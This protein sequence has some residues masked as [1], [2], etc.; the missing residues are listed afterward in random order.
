MGAGYS[1]S[2]PGEFCGSFVTGE[3]AF[4]SSWDQDVIYGI[5]TDENTIYSSLDSADAFLSCL[6]KGYPNE[7]VS[8]IPSTQEEV[9]Y[10]G[11]I[12]F[13]QESKIVRIYCSQNPL[14]MALVAGEDL[15]G[16]SQFF[17]SIQIT[18]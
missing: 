12:Q 17:D 14:Y 16:A 15:S 4:S 2:F 1:A 3:E 11:E 6:Q 10:I 7:V 8:L 5:F 18:K 9:S 13:N